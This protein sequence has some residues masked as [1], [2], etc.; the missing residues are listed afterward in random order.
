MKGPFCLWPQLLLSQKDKVGELIQPGDLQTNEMAEVSGRVK[1]VHHLEGSR[2]GGQQVMAG[3]GDELW[4]GEGRKF[5][6]CSPGQEMLE[7]CGYLE[8]K[9]RQFLSCV[10]NRMALA[11]ESEGH[12][13]RN[14]KKRVAICKTSG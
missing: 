9:V 5:V 14:Q 6:L 13:G 3:R 12:G 2:R 10:Y 1:S 11:A 8:S 4:E 7:R